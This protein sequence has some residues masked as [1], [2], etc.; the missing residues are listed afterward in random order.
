[1]SQ[2][3]I[4]VL[5]AVALLATG[6]G[7]DDRE[8]TPAAAVTP[9]V[10]AD[11]SY[12][13]GTLPDAEDAAALKAAVE[14]LPVAVSYDYRSLDASLTKATGAMTAGFA[15]EFRRI[16]DGATRA[17]ARTEQAITSALVRGAGVVSSDRGTVTCL[18]YLDQV[19]VASKF[20]KKG[21]PLKVTQNSVRV[22]MEKVDGAWKVAG[23]EPF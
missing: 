9:G 17:K 4:G 19:L 2:K 11:G 20:K 1:M 3:L 12:Q 16:F 13:L 22:R 18:V 15:S 8:A 10:Q 7:G 5:L 14:A 6:C 23:I 21:S